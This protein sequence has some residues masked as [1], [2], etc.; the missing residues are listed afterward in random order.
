[1]TDDDGDG[2]YTV[3]EGLTGTVEYKYAITVSRVK[4]LI[5]DMVD[6]ADCAP[7]TDFVKYANRQTE[8]G[9]TTS[10]YYGTCDGTCT[11]FLVDSLRSRWTWQG[12]LERSVPPTSMALQRMV[13][14]MC[15]DDRRRW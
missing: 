4:K 13:R 9:S 14:R 1:M 7:V 5:N 12:T 11:M 10:D 2:V 15:R 6:G 3:D 8:A